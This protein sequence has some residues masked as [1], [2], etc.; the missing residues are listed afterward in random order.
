MGYDCYVSNKRE[1]KVVSR[2]G[3]QDALNRGRVLGRGFLTTS[4]VCSLP[5][6]IRQTHDDAAQYS[7]STVLNNGLKILYDQKSR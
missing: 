5:G 3:A 2:F 4:S 7:R 6:Y 1:V